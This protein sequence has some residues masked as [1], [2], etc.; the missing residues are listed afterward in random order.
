MDMKKC[1][2][3]LALILQTP[4][5]RRG[6]PFFQVLLKEGIVSSYLVFDANREQQRRVWV[7]ES[8]CPGCGRVQRIDL[9]HDPDAENIG[10]FCPGRCP[11][12]GTDLLNLRDYSWA[13]FLKRQEIYDE[14]LKLKAAYWVL[15]YNC[16][17]CGKVMPLFFEKMP[18]EEKVW[19][20]N[21]CDCPECARK[22]SESD[23]RWY[24]LHVKEETEFDEESGGVNTYWTIERSCDVCGRV[25]LVRMDMK[26][27]EEQICRL[28]GLCANCRREHDQE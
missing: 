28:N 2:W 4:D 19:R 24:D 3:P 6:I 8:M 13:R 11:S 26:P 15:E 5:L 12:C 25:D 27:T 17:R 14:D 7:I 22:E 18:E 9:D 16:S 10:G 21:I 1:F 20:R 23:R